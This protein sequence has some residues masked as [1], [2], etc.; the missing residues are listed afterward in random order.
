M[1]INKSSIERGFA[2]ASTI[3]TGIIDFKSNGNISCST[4]WKN[5]KKFRLNTKKSSILRNK[6]VRSDTASNLNYGVEPRFQRNHD[7]L[8]SKPHYR[9]K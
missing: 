5:S 4:M 6:F 8:S 1:I 3:S 7:Y 9:G 2:H